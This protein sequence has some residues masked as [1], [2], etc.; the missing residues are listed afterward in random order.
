MKNPSVH[1]A[2]TLSA[3][4]VRLAI[5]ESMKSHCQR[6]F[7]FYNWPETDRCFNYGDALNACGHNQKGQP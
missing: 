7:L 2:L 4:A 3:Y 1:V 5:Q 6:N